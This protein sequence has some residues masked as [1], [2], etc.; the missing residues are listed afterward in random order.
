MRPRRIPTLT[1]FLS[2]GLFGMLAHVL[3][4]QGEE[5]AFEVT[6]P[7]RDN[8]EVGGILKVEGTATLPTGHHLWVF[9]R[10]VDFEPMWWPQNRGIVDPEDGTW[11]VEATIGEP[12]KDAGRFFDIAVAVFG[13]EA[14]SKLVAYRNESMQTGIWRPMP[15]PE[16]AAPPKLFKV[17]KVKDF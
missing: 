3:L 2:V 17:K 8:T 15:M 5:I 13:E 1:L 11:K 4:G 12:K 10:R 14:H 6:C 7:E 16:A 9:A